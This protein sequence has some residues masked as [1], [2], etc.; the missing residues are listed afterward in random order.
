MPRPFRHSSHPAIPFMA[1]LLAASL[2]EVSQATDQVQLAGH[3]NF[4]QGQSDNAAM[5]VR[6]AKRHIREAQENGLLVPLPGGASPVSTGGLG[7]NGGIGGIDTRNHAGFPTFSDNEWER[8]AE[9]PKFL[10]ISQRP[11]QIMVATDSRQAQF[12]YPDGIKHV[13]RDE[14]GKKVAIKA[15]WEG[16][17]FVVETR[18]SHSKKITQTFQITRDRKRLYVTTRIEISSLNEPVTIRRAYDLAEPGMK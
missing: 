15:N 2:G 6:Q 16:E 14:N 17:A 18:V 5:R 4:N 3:W 13:E 7:G 1:F 10:Q 12:F 9:D 8:L 11:D